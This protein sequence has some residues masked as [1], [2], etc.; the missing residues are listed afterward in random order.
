MLYEVEGAL[1]PRLAFQA[2][3]AVDLGEVYR[4]NVGVLFG[5][6][7]HGALGTP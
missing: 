7:W 1:T 3:V 5:L 6:T 4:D 2:A